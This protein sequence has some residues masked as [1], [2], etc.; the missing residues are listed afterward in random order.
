MLHKGVD[1]K[2]MWIEWVKTRDQRWRG[3]MKPHGEQLE[4]VKERMYRGF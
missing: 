2:S 3:I 1:G 4:N